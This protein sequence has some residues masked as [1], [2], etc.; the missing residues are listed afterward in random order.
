[1]C[2]CSLARLLFGVGSAGTLSALFPYLIVCPCRHGRVCSVLSR[3]GVF[4]NALSRLDLG[5]LCLSLRH[6]YNTTFTAFCQPFF[7][8]FFKNFSYAL[9]Y[10]SSSSFIK[11]LLYSR[12][13]LQLTLLLT[14]QLI[15]CISNN[16]SLQ[17]LS[18]HII[19]II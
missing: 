8:T 11:R 1:M 2:R 18:F 13:P 3:T 9:R 17:F 10:S 16:I 4:I 19:T 14:F 12:R 15:A 6:L 7:K 5:F